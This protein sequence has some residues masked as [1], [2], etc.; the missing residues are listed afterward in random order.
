MLLGIA[1]RI[2]EYNIS[3]TR[4]HLMFPTVML[5]PWHSMDHVRI[6][7]FVS[8]LWRVLF[9]CL[10]LLESFLTIWYFFTKK[11]RRLVF[12]KCYGVPNKRLPWLSSFHSA[13]FIRT[14]CL[15]IF[16]VFVSKVLFHV[17]VA[18]FWVLVI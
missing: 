11:R 18:W 4:Q 17:F 14:P 3:F 10:F 1:K 7:I 6:V 5:S 2:V 9:V 8:F 13:M 16:K 12:Q 15:L